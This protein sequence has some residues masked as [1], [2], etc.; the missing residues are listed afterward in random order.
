MLSIVLYTISQMCV[1]V[2]ACTLLIEKS[3]VS[4]LRFVSIL[5]LELTAATL[6]VKIS[7]ML[8]DE[9]DIHGDDE[10]FWANSKVFL[11][12]INSDAR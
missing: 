7:K 8:K 3:R 2:D 5:K 11:G 1:K 4:P 6:S 9:V 12:Y 10:I